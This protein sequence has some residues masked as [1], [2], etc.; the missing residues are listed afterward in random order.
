MYQEIFDPHRRR[1][2]QAGVHSSTSTS[3]CQT[4]CTLDEK[5]LGFEK[6]GPALRVNWLKNSDEDPT[7][8]HVRLRE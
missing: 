7:Q 2:I 4:A 8:F 5:L 6:Y 3:N 1:A